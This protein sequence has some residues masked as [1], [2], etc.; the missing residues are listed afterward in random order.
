MFYSLFLIMRQRTWAWFTC[1]FIRMCKIFW[2]KNWCWNFDWIR[3]TPPIRKLHSHNFFKLMIFLSLA[4][5]SLISASLWFSVRLSNCSFFFFYQIGLKKFLNTR[6]NLATCIHWHSC[7]WLVTV[8]KTGSH[9][10][11]EQRIDHFLKNIDSLVLVSTF[12][13]PNVASVWY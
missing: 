6:G 7:C 4:P 1:Y 12:L 8:I 11:P 9:V 5:Q 3:G 10:L 2:G 13:Q